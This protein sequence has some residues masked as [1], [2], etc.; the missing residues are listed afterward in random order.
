MS[1]RM[2]THYYA[3]RRQSVDKSELSL[4]L[5]NIELI[6]GFWKDGQNDHCLWKTTDLLTD[7]V[8]YVACYDFSYPVWLYSDIKEAIEDYKRFGEPLSF[9]SDKVKRELAIAS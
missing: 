9:G 1:T 4:D 5:D 7:Q 2:S 8:V 3:S 6:C